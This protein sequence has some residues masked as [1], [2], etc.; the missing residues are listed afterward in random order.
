M[1]AACTGTGASPPSPTATSSRSRAVTATARR[2]D[3]DEDEDARMVSSL[4]CEG[5]RVPLRVEWEHPKRSRGEAGHVVWLAGSLASLSGRCDECTV[6]PT[7]VCRSCHVVVSFVDWLWCV[8]QRVCPCAVVSVRARAWAA[9][10][11]DWPAAQWSA[12]SKHQQSA[13]EKTAVTHKNDN[14]S[15][16]TE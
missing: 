4:L 9:G 2:T 16:G 3:A 6:V 13:R 12:R 8:H 14:G 10:W 5:T 15:M 7:G 1:K 11:E